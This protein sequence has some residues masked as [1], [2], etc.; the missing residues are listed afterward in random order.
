MAIKFHVFANDQF[1]QTVEA[2]SKLHTLNTFMRSLAGTTTPHYGFRCGGDC[3]PD[4]DGW[5]TMHGLSPIKEECV[6]PTV[7]MLCLLLSL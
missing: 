4:L 3:M 5:Y 1:V 7:R 6:P 2:N